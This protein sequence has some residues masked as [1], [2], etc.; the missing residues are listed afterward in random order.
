M[1][2]PRKNRDDP[3][4]KYLQGLVAD[5]SIQKGEE[6][7]TMDLLLV[8]A[9]FAIREGKPIPEPFAQMLTWSLHQMANGSDPGTVWGTIRGPRP[10]KTFK[11]RGETRERDR[12]FAK[13]ALHLFL[14]LG[15]TPGGT[16]P[17]GARPKVFE[18]LSKFNNLSPEKMEKAW[19]SNKQIVEHLWL[20]C[21]REDSGPL[22]ELAGTS[23][24]LA[25]SKTPP[26]IS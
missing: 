17:R 21:E 18:A 4:S 16:M 9:G 11:K 20:A 2:K 12:L 14:Q 10:E 13:Q 24:F 6:S 5:G 7:K 23:R 19:D 3:W 1:T 25:P 22:A 8:K 26:E 15:Y